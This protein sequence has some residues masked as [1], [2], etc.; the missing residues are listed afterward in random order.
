MQLKRAKSCQFV[1]S[2]MVATYLNTGDIV[3]IWV[4]CWRIRGMCSFWLNVISMYVKT[5][6]KIIWQ[7]DSLIQYVSARWQINDWAIASGKA[8]VLTHLRVGCLQAFRLVSKIPQLKRIS[9]Y[10]TGLLIYWP[11]QDLGSEVCGF[12]MDISSFLNPMGAELNALQL[13]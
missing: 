5:D 8:S 10:K 7:K 13:Q 12:N 4:S 3:N 9:Y 6:G 2:G 11:I 1:V